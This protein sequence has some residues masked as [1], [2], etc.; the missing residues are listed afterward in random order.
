[1][2]LHTFTN[3]LAKKLF[4]NDL[5]GRFAKY[6]I[7]FPYYQ[8]W[9]QWHIS[10]W[11]CEM[12]SSS[13]YLSQLNI[14]LSVVNKRTYFF[15]VHKYHMGEKWEGPHWGQF[16][17]HLNR[18]RRNYFNEKNL[19]YCS[20]QLPKSNVWDIK[21]WKTLTMSM[22]CWSLKLMGIISARFLIPMSS[23]IKAFHVHHLIKQNL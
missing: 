8:K 15:R 23:K 9:P 6:F 5:L 20:K 16:W 12:E 13:Q 11:V 17:P 18:Q 10:T 22:T 4:G 1:M 14:G 2:I 3:I 19:W 21:E 7:T